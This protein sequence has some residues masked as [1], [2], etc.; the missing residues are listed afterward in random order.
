MHKMTNKKTIGKRI[1]NGLK[2]V[3]GTVLPYSIAASAVVGG[4]YIAYEGI[5]ERNLDIVN[6][7]LKVVC[8]GAAITLA[9]IVA[10]NAYTIRRA[11]AEMKNVHDNLER[12][13]NNLENA[14]SSSTSGLDESDSDERID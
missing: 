10:G 5:K 2:F 6:A 7:G 13:H 14:I 12:I 11:A 3:A 9:R 1:G 4:S 8:A